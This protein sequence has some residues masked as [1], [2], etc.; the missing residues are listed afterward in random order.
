MLELANTSDSVHSHAAIIFHRLLEGMHQM[1]YE[2]VQTLPDDVLQLKKMLDSGTEEKLNLSELCAKLHRSSAHMVRSFKTHLGATPY[3]YLMQKKI[4][5][6]R[7]LL[8]YSY[9][10][11][12]EIAAKLKFS[13][14]YYFSNYFR[15]KTGVSPQKYR[16]KTRSN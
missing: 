3:D 10:S 13:D 7:L 11:V 2:T 14:Q 15:R 4:V 9:L 16:A 8:H 12:K 1:L 6:A 5:A